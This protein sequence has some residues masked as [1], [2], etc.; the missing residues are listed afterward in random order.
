MKCLQQ[1]TRKYEMSVLTSIHQPNSDLLQIF[2]K[3]YVLSK[4]GN[5]LYFGKPNHLSTHLNEC[6][7]FCSQNEK[8]IETLL[9]LSAMGSRDKLNKQLIDKNFNSY[10]ISNDKQ[11]GGNTSQTQTNSKSFQIK[12]IYYLLMRRIQINFII[13]WK[14]LIIETVFHLLFVIIIRNAINE[15]HFKIDGCFSSNSLN[16]SYNKQ[17]KSCLEK[18]E[19]KTVIEQ[20]IYLLYITSFVFM[21]TTISITTKNLISEIESFSVELK[22]RKQ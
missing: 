18:E 4:D 1:L 16:S 17:V 7:I 2:D 14:T 5:C 11:I 6:Q 13:Q 15:N 20:N 8:P 10:Q 9:K 12:D 19:E 3:L 22:N 21:L